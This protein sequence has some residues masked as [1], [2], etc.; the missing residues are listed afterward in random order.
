MY[1]G[2]RLSPG[3]KEGLELGEVGEGEEDSEA[4]VG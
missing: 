4:D 2:D 1:G 3:G